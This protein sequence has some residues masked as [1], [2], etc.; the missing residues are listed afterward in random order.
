MP[1][2]ETKSNGIKFEV[3]V[4]GDGTEGNP[5][6]PAIFDTHPDGYYHLESVDVL[7]LLAVAW[8][9][10]ARSPE[11]VVDD[12]RNEVAPLG[13]VLEETSL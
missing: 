12:I 11:A 5:Y 7:N 6:Q 1:V 9:D 13:T 3:V 4:N 2:E 8:V 10:K